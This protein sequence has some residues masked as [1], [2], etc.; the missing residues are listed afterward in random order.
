M[1]RHYY[2][3]R[4]GR[5]RRKDNTLSFEP[6]AADA[7]AAEPELSGAMAQ[8]QATAELAG[9]DTLGA[10]GADGM[11][12]LLLEPEPIEDVTAQEQAAL[13]SEQQK[14]VVVGERRVIPVE[15]VDALWVFGEL[16]LNARVLVFL[17]QHK[18]PV[19]FFNYYGFY[20]GSF[21]PREYLHAGYLVVRQVRHYANRR[22]RLAIARE[23]IGAAL[24]NIMRNLRY[25]GTRGIAVQAQTESVQTETLRLATVNSV[26]ELMACEGRARAAYYQAFAGILRNEVDFTKRVRRPPDNMVNALIS[27][28]NGLVYSAALTQIYRTQL[29]PTISFLHEPG[30][31]RFSLALDLAEVFKPILADRL[32]FKL[33]NNRQLNERDFAQD[34]NCCYLKESGRKVVLK[35]WNARLETTIEHRRLRRKVSYERL[36]RLE[37]YKLIKHL[38]NVEPYI[39]F[40]A[41]W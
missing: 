21:Y 1:A 2:L 19:H 15:D 22:L 34:L 30:A 11:G 3:T 28:T 25:Y 38:T 27:F 36:I 9:A 7:P 33:L 35:E 16:D 4:A 24:H 39:G 23:F 37:C 17:A 8:A 40:R 41:W 31:R 32:L 20:A 14:P 12:D 18:V 26:D 10:V 29:D 13:E 5:L 6:T